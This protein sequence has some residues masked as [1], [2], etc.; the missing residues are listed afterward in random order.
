MNPS[1]IQD[2]EQFRLTTDPNDPLPADALVPS[3]PPGF[4][5]VT[6]LGIDMQNVTYWRFDNPVVCAT[7]AGSPC[8]P[9]V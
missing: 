9:P 4:Y 3:L 2:W 1:G 8:G 5:T 6:A 7:A